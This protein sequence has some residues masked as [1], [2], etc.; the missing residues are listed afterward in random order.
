[1]SF[2]NPLFLFALLT[3][4]VPLLIYLLNIKKPKRIQFSTLAFFESLKTTALKRIKIKRWLLLAVRVLAIIALVI[5]A[6]RPF[7]PPEFGWASSQEPKVIGVLIDNSPSMERVDRN[8]PYFEQ[9]VNLAS[10]LLSL[11]ENND[12]VVVNVTNG[13]SL[14]LPPLTRQAADR[15]LAEIEIVNAGN[16]L[17]ERI[18]TIRNQF[19]STGMSN[20]VLYL[21]SD[22]QESQFA[23]LLEEEFE[24]FGNLRVQIL[25][26]GDSQTVNVGFERV[27]IELGGLEEASSVQLRSEL[28]NFGDGDA[29]NI[30]LSL[31]IEEELISQQSLNIE[32]GATRDVVFDVPIGDSRNI[33]AELL[34]EGD[35]LS[36]DN[37]YYAAIRLPETREIL[38]LNE[39]GASR[40]MQSY[41]T[42]LLE[43]A[44]DESNRFEIRF[45]TADAIQVSDIFQFDAVILDG[46]RNIPDFLSQSLLEHVQ[47]GAGL[48]LL[49]A[50]DG[51]VASYNRL[52]SFSG[53]GSYTNVTGSYGS[54]SPIDRMAAPTEG[55]PILDMIFDKQEE[56]EIRL[57][58]PEIFYYYEIDTRDRG[59]DVT[60][61]RTTTGRPLLSEARVG[62]GRFIYSALGSDPGW[63]NFP[64][65]PFFAPLMYRT[66]DYLVQGEGAVIQSHTLGE[67]FRAMPGAG[68]D[69]AELEIGGETILPE[70]RQTFRGSEIIYPAVEWTPGWLQ[71]HSGENRLLF[72]VNQHAME[73]A[74][75]ALSSTELEESLAG[76]F[77]RIAVSSVADDRSGF[78]AE[79]EMASF[80]R[81]IWY[82]FVLMGILLLLLESLISRHY[83]AETIE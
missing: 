51:S 17:A 16:F 69:S 2:L 75:N 78:L 6:S 54:F 61:L 58:V 22:A 36:F 1:M 35:E 63:S 23:D 53:S 9:A 25:K 64:I 34:I 70:V 5:A 26:V 83:K 27:S 77:E 42:P 43:A 15:R 19:E 40:S 12:R 50:A 3:V 37:R 18:R 65:K 14:N 73:S 13:E 41:L 11:A 55:H 66:I 4:A 10:E 48:L 79:L 49:P 59:A 31:L 30:S 21:I 72:S 56:E 76:K 62:S 81:E 67:T 44:A 39:P 32:Q 7:L 60:I 20:S 71:I 28:R 68:F 46:I 82:W 47:A 24:E 52:L 33:A 57:N 74:L 45:E 8:G 80:G 38:V 29:N